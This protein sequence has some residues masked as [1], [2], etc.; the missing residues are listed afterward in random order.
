MDFSSGAIHC[1]RLLPLALPR[2]NISDLARSPADLS[3]L[4]T[5]PHSSTTESSPLQH[6]PKMNR[7][8]RH[9]RKMDKLHGIVSKAAVDLDQ[10]LQPL[11]EQDDMIKQQMDQDVNLAENL[12]HLKARDAL[13]QPRM[14]AISRHK[15]LVEAA[16][17]KCEPDGKTKELVTAF[18]YLVKTLQSDCRKLREDIQEWDEILNA[19]DYLQKE[20]QRLSQEESKRA[21]EIL[22][23]KVKEDK[24][25][26]LLKLAWNVM[27]EEIQCSRQ[28]EN[29]APGGGESS[30]GPK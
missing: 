8:P 10:A 19:I 12:A 16:A 7:S 22:E 30:S 15:D 24:Q 6:S 9:T 29:S 23:M 18:F 11:K 28:E 17:A 25:K 13:I 26:D 20:K 27:S 2:T 5:L 1:R 4:S 3:F 21:T 14:E